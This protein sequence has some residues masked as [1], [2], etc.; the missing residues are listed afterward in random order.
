MVDTSKQPQVESIRAVMTSAGKNLLP[1]VIAVSMGDPRGIGPEVIVRTVLS[2]D[3]PRSVK[4]IVFADAEVMDRAAA[5]LNVTPDWNVYSRLPETAEEIRFGHNALT[6]V[7]PGYSLDSGG[8]DEP[9]SNGRVQ[10]MYLDAAVDAMKLP[11]IRA[12]VTAPV[13]KADISLVEPGFRGHTQYLAAKAGI[14]PDTVTMIFADNRWAVA[15]VT[16]HVPLSEVA[17]SLTPERLHRSLDHLADVLSRIRKGKRLKIALAGLNPHAGEQGLIGGDEK[18][19]LAPWA[20][21]VR[22]S[23]K[24]PDIEL[25]GPAVPDVVFRDLYNGAYD[26]VLA[27][28]HDQALIPLKLRGIGTWTNITAGLPYCRTS[29]DHGVARDLAGTGHSDPAGMKHAILA[30]MTLS[31]IR[32]K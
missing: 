13:S 29:P 4:L 10:L 19:L 15:L 17:L 23:G 28:Y 9:R 7:D 22:K 18:N 31:G 24:Y 27:L 26:G 11:W 16:G 2:K 5:T 30:A 1:H 8:V 21:S 12:L 32:T 14:D 3:M 25:S 20:D 6:I